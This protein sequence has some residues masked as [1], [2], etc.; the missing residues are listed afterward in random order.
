MLKKYEKEIKTYDIGNKWFVD[1]EVWHGKLTGDSRYDAWL[2]HSDYGVKMHLFGV[3]AS[4]TK[5]EQFMEAAERTAMENKQVYY[6]L[7]IVDDDDVIL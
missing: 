5:W 4:D 1:I 2:Y 3:F 6:N 7:Y